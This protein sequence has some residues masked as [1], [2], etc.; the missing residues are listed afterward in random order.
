MIVTIDSSAHAVLK[1]HTRDFEDDE[2]PLAREIAEQL[3]SAL[4]PHFPAAGLAAP[5]IGIARSIFIYS[6]DRDPAHLQA[7]INPSFVP[8]DERRVEGWEGCLSVMLGQGPWRIAKLPR[9][10]SILAHYRTI[11]GEIVRITL[12]GFAAKVFQHEYDH[13]KGVVNIYRNDAEVKSF[14][15]IEALHDFM[16]QVKKQD[17]QSYKKPH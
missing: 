12:D 2:W 11:D 14:E 9:Y 3:Y 15:T 10:E 8:V 13:L 7:A 6:Y 17:A 5:Q 1:Q 16:A 4:Q